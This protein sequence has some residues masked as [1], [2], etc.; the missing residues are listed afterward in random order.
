MTQVLAKTVIV[1]ELDLTQ[2]SFNVFIYTNALWQKCYN[3]HH[4]DQLNQSYTIYIIT[5]FCNLT[6][7]S[8]TYFLS[9]SKTL[10]IEAVL[11]TKSKDVFIYELRSKGLLKVY[12]QQNNHNHGSQSKPQRSYFTSLFYILF[13]FIF[14]WIL[15]LYYNKKYISWFIIGEI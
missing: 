7:F 12:L 10:L 13:Y 8:P 11:G 15:N 1:L 9:F 3:I 14:L 4:T 5:V 6:L 2:R